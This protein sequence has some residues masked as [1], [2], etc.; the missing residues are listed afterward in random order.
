MSACLALAR[1]VEHEA[2]E[3]RRLPLASPTPSRSKQLVGERAVHVVAAERLSPPV[4]FT[5]KTPS[6]SRR[7]VTSKVPPPRS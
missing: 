5:W 6:S 4:D 2:H 7:I 3:L 1:R